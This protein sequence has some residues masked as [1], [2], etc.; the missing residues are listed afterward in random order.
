[1]DDPQ[2]YRCFEMI[3]H[4]YLNSCLNYQISA[5]LSNIEIPANLP[6]SASDLR[7]HFCTTQAPH[8]KSVSRDL[9]Q[10][11][12]LLD[13]MANGK[14]TNQLAMLNLNLHISDLPR[15]KR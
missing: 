7:C 10:S 9:A 8:P 4:A 5:K 6:I 1:M 3:F 11:P 12:L 2:R 15:Q 13:F 14:L